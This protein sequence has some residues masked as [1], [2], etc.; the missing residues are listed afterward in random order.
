VPADAR[1]VFAAELEGLMDRYR[2]LW[3][4]RNRPGGLDDSLSWL[5][6][7]RAAYASGKPDPTWGG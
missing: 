7:L 3:L 1:N 6:N 4:A 5:L 2:R